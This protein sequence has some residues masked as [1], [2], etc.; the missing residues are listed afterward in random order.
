MCRLQRKE[1][2]GL[3]RGEWEGEGENWRS[4]LW[5]ALRDTPGSYI[6]KKMI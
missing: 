6:D 1:K 5:D 3:K 2:G 4:D